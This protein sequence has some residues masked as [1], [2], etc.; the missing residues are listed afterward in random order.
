MEI[1]A[2]AVIYLLA[3]SLK[4]TLPT[5]YYPMKRQET[6]TPTHK[7]K[8]LPA[9]PCNHRFAAKHMLFSHRTRFVDKAVLN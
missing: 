1:N 9:H 5:T 2:I 8:S 3:T 4:N 7:S 6:N